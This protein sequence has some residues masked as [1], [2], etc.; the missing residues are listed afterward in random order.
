MDSGELIN[1][2]EKL[3]AVY[4]NVMLITRESKRQYD[5]NNTSAKSGYKNKSE[6]ELFEEFYNSLSN[7]EFTKEKSKVVDEIIN[8]VLK[9]EM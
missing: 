6:K 8:E 2:I 5:E 3:R 9:G 4:P 1:P 7:G